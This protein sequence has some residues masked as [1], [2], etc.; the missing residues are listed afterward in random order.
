MSWGVA[1]Q[2]GVSVSLASIVSL[3]CGAT[4]AFSPLSLFTSGVQGAWY[5][6][7]DINSYTTGLGAELVTP[8]AN[9][10][11]SSDTGYWTKTGTTTISG[12]VCNIVGSTNQ[13]INRDNVT[14]VGSFYLVQFEITRVTSGS[15]TAQLGTGGSAAFNTI[16]VKQVILQ[17][18]SNR[19]VRFWAGS[20]S[21]DIDIDNI[22]VQEVTSIGNATMFQDSAGTTPVTAVEQPV[23]LMLDKS[24]GATP[25]PELVT[26]GDFSSATG[27]T[28]PAGCTVSGGVLNVS[29]VGSAL[30]ETTIAPSAGVR[31]FSFQTSP[32][33]FTAYVLTNADP[34]KAVI[35]IGG[36]GLTGTLD[37]VS[38]KAIPGNHASQATTASR[39][40]LRARYNQLTYSEDLTNAAW[41][42]FQAT[43]NNAS[44]FTADSGGGVGFVFVNQSFTTFG[45]VSHVFDVEFKY[46]NK[47]WVWIEASALASKNI[48]AWFDV[49][50]GVVGSKTVDVTSSSIVAVG[51]GWYR[52]RIVFTGDAA[53][54]SGSMRLAMS[55]ADNS[56]NCSRDGTSTVFVRNSDFRV[57]TSIA[58]YQRIAAATDYATAGFLPYLAL[59][60]DDSLS[61]G[62][63]DFTA[64]DAMFA[65][66]GITKNSDAANSLVYELSADL[67]SNNGAVNL[68]APIV[69]GGLNT[70]Y[71]ASKGTVSAAAGTGTGV[72]VAPIT[73]VV[74]MVSDISTPSLALRVNGSQVATSTA[75]QGTGNYGNYPLYIGRR[76]NATLPLNGNI[77]QLIVC[78]KT[79]SASELASTEAFVNSKTGA[80]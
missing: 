20:A 1:T 66:A 46:S 38:V 59:V 64:T 2:N 26:N 34:N 61:T 15:V 71:A 3:S 77:Y 53:D 52:C 48:R 17:A 58:T 78:G 76:N 30:V 21:T 44:Q 22:S 9:R 14:T 33:T 5:D 75:T 67:N 28:L 35:Q 80:Y 54:L 39:P 19:Q 13:G 55:D 51:S 45:A 63:I 57:G 32:G 31:W 6:P 62:S 74:S 29:T 43:K 16:G 69:S 70:Y 25:G 37:N 10:D 4:E 7:S 60:T 65:C 12:G 24:Q 56:T 47:Q 68:F 49:Q 72:Y 18:A 8:D 41:S 11:F 23:G 79:L 50:N 27:W 36:S 40:V 73:N 42:A